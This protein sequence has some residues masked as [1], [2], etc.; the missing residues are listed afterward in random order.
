MWIVTDTLT[1]AGDA[2]DAWG[3]YGEDTHIRIGGDGG[4]GRIRVDCNEVN[5]I[6]CDTA[7][8]VLQLE[9]GALPS[10]GWIATP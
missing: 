4:Y 5:G 1:L 8:G 9:A 7:D 6:G 10:P 3:G 2:L